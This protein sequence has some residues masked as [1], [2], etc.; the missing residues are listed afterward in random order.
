MMENVQYMM[1]EF[2]TYLLNVSYFDD[3]LK[4]EFVTTPGLCENF[5]IVGQNLMLTFQK[6]LSSAKE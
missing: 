6:V 2:S 3:T 4:Y 5:M 1:L